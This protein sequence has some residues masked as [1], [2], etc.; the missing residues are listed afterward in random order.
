[1]I[2]LVESEAFGD[3]PRSSDDH[4][5]PSDSAAPIEEW[6]AFAT[7]DRN[8]VCIRDRADV[9]VR[10]GSRDHDSELCGRTITH[11]SSMGAL[12]PMEAR[13]V[14][15]ST[16]RIEGGLLRM[17]TERGNG[18][19][20][21]AYFVMVRPTRSAS[22]CGWRT[23]SWRRLHSPRMRHNRQSCSVFA[24][25]AFKAGGSAS[26]GIDSGGLVTGDWEVTAGAGAGAAGGTMCGVGAHLPGLPE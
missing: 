3:L 6:P 16:L 26:V 11:L 10:G 17:E 1:M 9:S 25:G 19:Q 15:T 22:L 8:R 14:V 24:A 2:S 7:P 18:T 4:R 13:S 12:F 5:P 20:S 23:H 21:A